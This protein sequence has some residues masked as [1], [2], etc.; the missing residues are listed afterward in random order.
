M[1]FQEKEIVGDARNYTWVRVVNPSL[2][3]VNFLSGRYHLEISLIIDAMDPDELA[4]NETLTTTKGRLVIMRLPYA[5][6]GKDFT[7][8]TL[9]FSSF[10]LDDAGII[11]TVCKEH[12]AMFDQAIFNRDILYAPN[13]SCFVLNILLHA[14]M[15]YLRYLKELKNIADNLEMQ[16]DGPVHNQEV[17]NLMRIEKSL[18]YFKTSLRSNEILLEKIQKSPN[19]SWSAKEKELLDDVAIEM[20]EAVEISEIYL[21]ILHSMAAAFSSVTNNNVNQAM[22]R[23][24]VISLVLMMPTVVASFF[25]MN[26]ALPV[27]YGENPLSFWLIAGISAAISTL[28]MLTLK[29][30]KFF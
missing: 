17:V 18:H 7:H 27:P 28:M 29:I 13:L 12:I 25:G 26:V 5:H 16:L 9:T 30:R 21:N 4:R 2:E 15:E 24:T 1:I 23:L 22:K 20:R 3:E 10:L 19:W 8:T 14:G 6:P 11:I